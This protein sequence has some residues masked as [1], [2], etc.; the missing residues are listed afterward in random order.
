MRRACLLVV[1]G[2]AVLAWA[3]DQT[4]TTP[5]ARVTAVLRGYARGMTESR[6]D[7]KSRIITLDAAG[8]LKKVKNTTHRLEFTQGHFRG[9]DP[10]GDVDWT[11]SMRIRGNRGTLSIEALTDMALLFP[12][13][14]LAPSRRGEWVFASSTAPDASSVTVSYRPSQPCST[15]EG[16]DEGFQFNEK[17][18]A[19]GN[20]VVDLGAA[21]PLRS[22]FD[23]LGLP[24]TSP[25]G[26]TVLK[27]YHLEADFQTAAIPGG[28]APFAFPKTAVSTFTFADKRV[29]VECTYTL[30]TDGQD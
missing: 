23:A 25:S 29:V 13:F 21:I 15:F 8:K 30:H 11:S 24:L 7:V 27:G 22:S 1:A 12:V 9:L 2:C 17:M 14:I 28:K 18:C 3:Q 4:G 19:A 26:K 20:V 16:S 5:P 10:E 6:F